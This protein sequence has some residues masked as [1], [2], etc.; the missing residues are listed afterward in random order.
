MT[1]STTS[2]GGG[3]V[4]AGAKNIRRVSQ[5][6]IFDLREGSEVSSIRMVNQLEFFNIASKDKEE[7]ECYH[8]NTIAETEN[9]EEADE[10]Y[11]TRGER[12]TLKVIVD[13]GADASI[14]PGRLMGRTR[15]IRC[16]DRP[17]T[18]KML[19]ERRS[20]DMATRMWIS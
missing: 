16:G 12:Q 1:T 8:V 19:K 17:F 6:V 7:D 18:C 9:E 14:F 20:R 13:S 4:N 10:A 2:G 3:D 15:S 11:A 5:P